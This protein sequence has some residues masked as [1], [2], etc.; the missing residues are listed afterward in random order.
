MADIDTPND[1]PLALELR[2]V[3]RHYPAPGRLL[4]ARSFIPA[5]RGV[6]LQLKA[7][8]TLGLVG[9]SGCGKSTLARLV[10]GL[11]AA[12]AGEV[13]LQGQ[14]AASLGRLER[15]RIVQPVLQDPYSSL[16]PR[17]DIAAIIGA[18]LRIHAVGQS[19]ERAQSVRRMMD[20][21]GLSQRLAQQ[22]PHQ[23]SGGQRQRVAI[24]RA[25][26]LH[27]RIVVCDEP[28][29][30]LDVSVQA[31]ILNLLLELQRELGLTILLISHNLAVVA[32][33]SDRVAVMYAGRIVEEAHAQDLFED[34]R[35]PYTRAL[36]SALLSP[37]VHAG[38]PAI[39]DLGQRPSDPARLPGGCAYQPHCP[40]A[41][42]KCATVKPISVALL[43]GRAE[44]HLFADTGPAE[45]AAHERSG[46]ASIQTSV[47]GLL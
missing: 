31:Q 20:L 34:G 18:P 41:L 23:L 38:L 42:A 39:A 33:M 44:C 43:G 30:S 17:H 12:D 8:E 35:H 47:S 24:A 11:E 1:A 28:T 21:V 37:D 46:A 4:R 36:I 45:P 16:N 19:T 26:V 25:L 2:D 9:E 6:S 29:S 22:R 40:Q 7:G 5:L 27:P 32:H 14:P 13:F 10:I 3:V 15:A